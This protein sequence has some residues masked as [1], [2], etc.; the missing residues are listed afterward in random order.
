MIPSVVKNPICLI[1]DENGEMKEE[2]IFNLSTEDSY[3]DAVER[4]VHL[5]GQVWTRKY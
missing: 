4:L 3:E 5:R 2:N 1:E